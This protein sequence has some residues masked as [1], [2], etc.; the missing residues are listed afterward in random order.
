M[1]IPYPCSED[2]KLGIKRTDKPTRI[3]LEEKNIRLFD[4]MEGQF[5]VIK[6][7]DGIRTFPQLKSQILNDAKIVDEIRKIDLGKYLDVLYSVKADTPI[8]YNHAV[9]ESIIFDLTKLQQL[10]GK[11]E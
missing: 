3:P 9:L 7:K 10:L 8:N 1:T 6:L 11:K 4:F 2:A 5:L